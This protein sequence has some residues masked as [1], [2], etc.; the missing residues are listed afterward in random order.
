MRKTNKNVKE[1]ILRTFKNLSQGYWTLA[2]IRSEAQSDTSI[3][4]IER[5]EYF[6]V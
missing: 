1:K 6:K 2:Q 5:L 4:H 3:E